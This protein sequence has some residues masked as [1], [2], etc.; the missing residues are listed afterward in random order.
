MILNDYI[1]LGLSSIIVAWLHGRCYEKLLNI[2]FKTNFRNIMILL[3]FGCL[4]IVNNYLISSGMHRIIISVTLLTIMY[5]LMF[6]D[7]I[8]ETLTDAM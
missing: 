8:K 1:I 3:L 4:F 6:N 5:K 2:R 7:T